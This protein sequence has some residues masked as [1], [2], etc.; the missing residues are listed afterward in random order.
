MMALDKHGKD[1]VDAETA[2]FQ[3]RAEADPRLW[4]ELYSKPHPYAWMID[5]NQTAKLHDEI[6]TDPAAYRARVVAEERAK[7]ESERGNGTQPSPVAGMLPSPRQRAKFRATVEQWISVAP[8]VWMTFWKTTGAAVTDIATP[9]R[10]PLRR[11]TSAGRRRPTRI[12]IDYCGGL[13]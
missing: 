11:T 7:W 6:G 9:H 3:K 12:G 1:V 5:N 13:R 2:Y 10:H 4:N 8:S